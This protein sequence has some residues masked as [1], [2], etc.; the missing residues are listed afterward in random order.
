[1]QMYQIG[2]DYFN[3]DYFISARKKNNTV[4]L[5]FWEN[6]QVTITSENWEEIN[7]IVIRN[8][9]KFPND[10]KPKTESF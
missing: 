5:Y 2:D 4:T 7:K 6:Q 3:F 10:Y 9:A 8:V 1:M